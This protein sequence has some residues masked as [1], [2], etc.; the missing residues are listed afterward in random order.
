MAVQEMATV[1]AGAKAAGLDPERYKFIRSNLSAVGPAPSSY[2]EWIEFARTA[3]HGWHEEEILYP[4]H[5]P[6][7]D[8]KWGHLAASCFKRSASRSCGSTG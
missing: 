4:Y 3:S 1:E 8:A 2:D 7:Y 6:S 5:E